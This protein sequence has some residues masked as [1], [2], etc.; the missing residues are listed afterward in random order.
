MNQRKT[1]Q[2]KN[3]KKHKQV[4]HKKENKNGPQTPD[5]RFNPISN[6]RKAN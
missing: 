6:Q 2:W 5:K 4:C 3:G 1:T